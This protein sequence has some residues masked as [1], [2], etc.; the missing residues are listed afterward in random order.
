MADSTTTTTSG[1][2]PEGYTRTT[3]DIPDDFDPILRER[4]LAQLSGPRQTFVGNIADLQRLGAQKVG[5]GS[6]AEV[7][8]VHPDE[9]DNAENAQSVEDVNA[10]GPAYTT[11]GSNYAALPEP[12]VE[13][14]DESKARA[15]TQDAVKKA[16]AERR[17]RQG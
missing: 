6:E 15:K 10:P 17:K 7:F 8:Q 11:A 13:A 16:A 14:T 12:Q 2:A 4:L 3:V 1:K 5:G 9:V